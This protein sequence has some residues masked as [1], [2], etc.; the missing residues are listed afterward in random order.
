M[1]K[2]LPRGHVAGELH[3]SCFEGPELGCPWPLQGI[4]P[5]LVPCTQQRAGVAGEIPCFCPL[6]FLLC[7][8][9]LTHR[10]FPACR[11]TGPQIGKKAKKAKHPITSPVAAATACSLHTVRRE[12][13]SKESPLSPLC[14]TFPALCVL[15]TVRR[16]RGRE[17][18]FLAFLPS[19]SSFLLFDLKTSP[20]ACSQ[21]APLACSSHMGRRNG[22]GRVA[23]ASSLTVLCKGTRPQN[24]LR[25]QYN[26]V[27]V[28]HVCN[29][30]ACG[31]YNTVLQSTIEHSSVLCCRAHRSNWQHSLTP[32]NTQ[33]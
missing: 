18:G 27:M 10:L 1:E 7:F 28:Y 32:Q 29:S 4:H 33:T 11:R 16:D 26:G 31:L 17:G 30:M 12:Q 19:S 13:G 15:H 5:S 22:G 2:V 25:M 14:S 24:S 20:N 23:P 3:D 8:I 9:F 6:F 21:D